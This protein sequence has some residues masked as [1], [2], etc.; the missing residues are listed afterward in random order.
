MLHHVPLH[1]TVAYEFTGDLNEGIP[2]LSEAQSVLWEKFP[3]VIPPGDDKTRSRD[4]QSGVRVLF[5]AVCQ[6]RFDAG[7][8][9]WHD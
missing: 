8:K 9:A 3:N 7:L 6:Q 1:R 2:H 4:Y 5:C